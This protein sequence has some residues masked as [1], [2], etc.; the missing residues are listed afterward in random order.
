M[1][2]SVFDKVKVLVEATEEFPLDIKCTLLFTKEDLELYA[3][4]KE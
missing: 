2:F 3:Q 4:R 1:I